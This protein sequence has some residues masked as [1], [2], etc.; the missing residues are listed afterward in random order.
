[1]RAYRSLFISLRTKFLVLFCLMI[2]IPFLISGFITYQKYKA[3]MER[4]AEAYSAQVTEQ[5]SISLDRFVK[6]MERTTTSLYFDDL[7]LQILHSHKGPFRKDNYLKVDEIGKMNQLMASAVMDHSEI[8]GI[9]V[10][11]L[12]GSLFSNL[13]ETVNQSWNA[14]QN[15]WMIRAKANDGGLTIIPP[16]NESYYK[17]ESPK[18]MSLT[19]LIKDPITTEDLGY[20]KVDL[21]SKEFE[22]ILSTVK[23]TKSSKLYVFNDSS[24]Q[25]YPFIEEPGEHEQQ[26]VAA[27]S[28]KFMISEQTTKYGG[29]RVVS[30]I[31][32][33]DVQT[34]ARQLISFTIW[35]SVGAIVAAYFAAIMTS[36]RMVKP[37]L[38]LQKKMRRVQN[39]DFHERADSGGP[40]DEI[41]LLT[42]GFNIMVSQLEHMIK[43]MYELRLREKESE[44]SALQSQINPHFL[45]NTLES[46]RM[47]AQKDHKDE[48]SQVITS[49]AKML[50]Y[51]V[52]KQMRLVF[53]QE[54]LA[55]VESYLDIQSFRLEKMLEHEI[56]VDFSQEM[57]L[58]PKLLLQ[59]LVEN[60]IEHGLGCEPLRILIATKE[61]E[62]DLYI[63]ITDNGT[64]MNQA[65]RQMV[66]DRMNESSGM[67]TAPSRENGSRSKG[68]ALR[69]I[70]QRLKIL[71]GDAYGLTIEQSGPEGTTFCICIP[72]QWEDA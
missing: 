42:E 30:M 12:D 25:M 23:V 17:T 13:Q 45:Y 27:D 66:E 61:S 22:Q 21:T 47:V 26:E 55:F 2:T 35:I 49:L 20:V 40:N 7:V 59:P 32:K 44:L 10:F 1:M 53:L 46:I 36:N 72:F 37:I 58:V 15:L 9:F 56:H 68:F 3:N 43:D 57:A 31:P 5:V 69:N 48:L 11:A 14:S 67:Q 39:G 54:E 34:E 64:G 29:L 4:D 18:V 60:A 63:Y 50:R 6:E 38:H 24:Q 8:E 62:G 51:T 33:S 65:Q 70:Q 71:Y 41:G 16:Q 28:S 19:R 52:N